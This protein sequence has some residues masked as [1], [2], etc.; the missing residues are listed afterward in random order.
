MIYRAR[1]KTTP[2]KGKDIACVESCLKHNTHSRA[3]PLRGF[4]LATKSVNDVVFKGKGITKEKG[5]G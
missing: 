4:T 2:S 3:E 5:G 1:R